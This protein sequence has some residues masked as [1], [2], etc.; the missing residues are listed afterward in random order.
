MTKIITTIVLGIVF[1]EYVIG[2][3]A[4]VFHFFRYTVRCRNVHHCKNTKCL[5]R[6]YCKKIAFTMEEIERIQKQI[7][8]MK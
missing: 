8:N 6:P 4:L 7:D 2:W 5:N 3:I 1:L